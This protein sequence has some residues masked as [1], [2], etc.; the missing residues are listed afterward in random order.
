MR[1]GQNGKPI[2]GGREYGSLLHRLGMN[3][4]AQLASLMTSVHTHLRIPIVN[5][6]RSKY[7]GA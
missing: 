6:I 7:P 3:F 1:N 5:D 4:A 2:I